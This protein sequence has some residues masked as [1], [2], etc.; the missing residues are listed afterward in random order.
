MSYGVPIFNTSVT[1]TLIIE[2][3]DGYDQHEYLIIQ[4]PSA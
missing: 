2:D 1:I 4:N 3:Q